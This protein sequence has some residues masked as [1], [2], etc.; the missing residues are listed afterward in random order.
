MKQLVK[1]ELHQGR[2]VQEMININKI[3][4]EPK[5]PFD[6]YLLDLVAE[7]D[8]KENS[9]YINGADN[10]IREIWEE[11]IQTN[12]K[13]LNV[14]KLIPEKFGVTTSMFYAYKNGRK[15]ISIQ[16]LY[17]LLLVWQEYCGKTDEEVAQ[18]R[19]EIFNNNFAFSTHSK[20]QKTILPKELTPRLS[21]LLGWLCG[22]GHFKQSHNYLV[23]ISEKS[24][25]QLRLVLKPLFSDLFKIDVPIFQRY[26]GGYAIQVGSKPV[27]RFLT[28][29]LKIKVGEIPKMVNDMDETNK[30]H[31]LAGIFDSEGYVASSYL[32]SRIVISQA[33]QNFLKR[34]NKISNELDIHFTGPYFHKTKLGIWYTIQI[35]KKSEILKFAN[36]IGSYHVD[37]SQKLQ[38]LVMKIE[39]NRHR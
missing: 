18:K 16:M 39:K 5:I 28:K 23:K 19:N 31:F 25:D 37:K 10:F 3:P 29:V 7:R 21:Y 8:G 4:D 13:K 1:E 2:G 20:H 24:T 38:E 11:V 35:R 33:D 14:R 30:K 34:V 32:D 15:A 6:N 9:L 12:W 36:L 26:M 27:F 17:K 22:D